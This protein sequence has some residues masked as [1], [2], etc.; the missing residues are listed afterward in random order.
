M[1][2]VQERVSDRLTLCRI[3]LIMWSLKQYLSCVFEG[4]PSEHLFALT[5]FSQASSS[6]PKP[7]K[8]VLVVVVLAA[9]KLS[10]FSN[11]RLALQ[12]I[13]CVTRSG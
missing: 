1:R 13:I 11:F 12:A 8:V 9:K 10:K 7:L 2:I 4:Q 3:L 5:E 6:D